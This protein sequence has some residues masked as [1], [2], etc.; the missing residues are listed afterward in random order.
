MLQFQ[1]HL[2]RAFFFF[3]DDNNNNN[4]NNNQFIKPFWQCI[5]LNY[6]GGQEYAEH[7]VTHGTEGKN[8]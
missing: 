7:I 3:T 5:T 4:N 1:Q 8:N 6:K 2:F